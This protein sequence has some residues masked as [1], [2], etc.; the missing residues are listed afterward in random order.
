[1]ENNDRSRKGQI[2]RFHVI[3]KNHLRSYHTREEVPP[4]LPHSAVQAVDKWGTQVHST[5]KHTITTEGE[6]AFSNLSKE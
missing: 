1:M 5:Y 2:K 6:V 3:H 4:V